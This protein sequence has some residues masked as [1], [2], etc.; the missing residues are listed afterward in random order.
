MTNYNVV[1]LKVVCYFIAFDSTIDM[2]EKCC[3]VWS[4]FLG[5]ISLWSCKIEVCILDDSRLCI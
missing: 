2:A 5:Y 3:F 4:V 1:A